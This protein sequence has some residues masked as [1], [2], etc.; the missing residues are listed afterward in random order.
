MSNDDLIAMQE[1]NKAPHE[2]QDDDEIIQSPLT[3]TE[4]E[5]PQ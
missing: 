4:C 1:A 5:E 3:K 2:H